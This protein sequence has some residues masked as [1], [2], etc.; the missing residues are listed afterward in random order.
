MADD[1]PSTAVDDGTPATP[2]EWQLTPS[3][4]RLL[5]A[6]LYASWTLSGGFAA[7]CLGVFVGAILY[8][9]GLPTGAREIVALAIVVTLP[10]AWLLLSWL[11]SSRHGLTVLRLRA[12]EPSDPT[13]SV[14]E[15]APT[16]VLA[17]LAV[18]GAL[19]HVAFLALV[20]SRDLS[21]FA[22]ILPAGVL[23]GVL[24]Y[25]RW[26]LPTAGGID[27]PGDR[28]VLTSFPR[29]GDGGRVWHGRLETTFDERLS[30]VAIGRSVAVGDTAVVALSSGSRLP[31][32]AVVPV[33]AL[34][35]LARPP[36][37]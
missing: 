36:A 21:S 7:L 28:L 30:D 15:H 31:L 35:R 6:L 25:V 19:V 12:P 8:S 34:A 33:G 2:L 27:E 11:S 17:V 23:Y 26:W 32:V 5:R 4:S 24:V 1:V 22:Y 18:G 37:R 14:V 16:P 29:D 20:V 13:R 10:A 3:N 9:L